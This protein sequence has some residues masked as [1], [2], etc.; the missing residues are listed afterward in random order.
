MPSKLFEIEEIGKIKVVRS[1]RSKHIRLSIKADNTILVSAPYWTP[2]RIALEFVHRKKEWIKSNLSHQEYIYHGDK[3]GKA[4]R[5]LIESTDVKRPYSTIKNNEIII[6]FPRSMEVNSPEI[7]N[8]IK[9]KSIQALTIEAESL[10]PQRIR[11]ISERNGLPYSS[12]TI[13]S[14]KS[15]WGSCNSKKEIALSCY[16]MQLSWKEIDYV[17]TH[18]LAHTKHMSHDKSFWGLVVSKMPDAIEVKKI[19]KTKK[20][21]IIAQ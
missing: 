10:L 6:K 2:Y 9:K 3:I 13:K 4:H 1:K 12:V 5:L 16:L 14:M 18:E 7:Q 21:N 11:V 17:I 15:R 8:L 20:P 19:L